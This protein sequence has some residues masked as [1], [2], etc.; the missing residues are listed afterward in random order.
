MSNGVVPFTANDI[1]ALS[2]R[3][4]FILLILGCENHICTYT[5]IQSH[6]MQPLAVLWQTWLQDADF[7]GI[8]PCMAIIYF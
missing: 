5:N 7:L 3:P 1:V 8:R 6:Y 2:P 4:P